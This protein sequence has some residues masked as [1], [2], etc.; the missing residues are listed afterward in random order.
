M[1]PSADHLPALSP[2]LGS[3]IILPATTG[4]V[5]GVPVWAAELPFPPDPGWSAGAQVTCLMWVDGDLALPF[6]PL[7]RDRAETTA[8]RCLKVRTVK[9]EG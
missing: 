4:S 1:F 2:L 5:S 3:P 6:S 9:R 7:V 8:S